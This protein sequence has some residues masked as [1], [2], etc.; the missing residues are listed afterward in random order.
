VT[1]DTRLATQ[2]GMVPIG[3]LYASG[4]Q[5]NVSVDR[6][7]LGHPGPGV[8][9][10]PAVPAFMTAASADVYRVVTEAGYE[11]KATEW[12]D[13]YTSRGKIKLKDLKPGDELFIQSGKG[14]FGSEGSAELGT[15][16]GLITGDGHFTNRGKG[17]QAAIVNLW[18]LDRDYAR[19]VVSSINAMI[20]GVSEKTRD[21]QVSAVAVPERNLVMIRSVLLARVLERYGFSAKTK[22]QIPEVATRR[23]ECLLHHSPGLKSSLFAEGCAGVTGELWH[24]QPHVQ[25]PRRRTTHAAR[26]QRRQASVRLQSRLRVVDRIAIARSLHGGNRIPH[27]RQES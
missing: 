27:R 3:E 16:L 12:H 17:E 21:Y 14:Q 18:G 2:F 6:R 15:L 19:T 7:A 13:F 23:Q 5:L 20:A 1:A 8:E 22:K 9:V 4:A 25:A 10:R 26:W 11:I 24:F